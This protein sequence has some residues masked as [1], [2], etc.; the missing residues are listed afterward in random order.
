MKGKGE[1][2]VRGKRVM[3]IGELGKERGAGEVRDLEIVEF[4]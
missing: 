3:M 4:F 2:K 1:K